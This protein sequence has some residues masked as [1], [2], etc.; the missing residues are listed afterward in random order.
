MNQVTLNPSLA[1]N[2]CLLH[3]D[4][5]NT[6]TQLVTIEVRRDSSQ[7]YPHPQF[8]FGDVVILQEQHLEFVENFLNYIDLTQYRIQAI[9]LIEESEIS[10][11]YGVYPEF[12]ERRLIWFEETELVAYRDLPPSSKN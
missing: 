10:W 9:Q 2:K 1:Q 12:G 8:T 3:R 4:N 5:S 7:H 11:R 6:D